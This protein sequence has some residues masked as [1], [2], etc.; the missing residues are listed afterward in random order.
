MSCCFFQLSST[1]LPKQVNKY[2]NGQNGSDSDSNDFT[3]VLF[4]LSMT[5]NGNIEKNHWKIKTFLGIR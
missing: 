5:V 4:I 2:N 3:A 1:C